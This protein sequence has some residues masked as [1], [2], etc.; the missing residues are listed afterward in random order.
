LKAPSASTAS[1]AA[2]TRALG[3]RLSAL[4]FLNFYMDFQVEILSGISYTN[5]QNPFYRD[6]PAKLCD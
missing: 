6:F 3:R 5:F 2:T 4:L 1:S